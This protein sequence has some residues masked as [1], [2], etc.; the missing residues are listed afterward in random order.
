[1]ETLT[2]TPGS[3]GRVFKIDEQSLV[4]RLVDIRKSS[5]GR[6]EWT[7]TSGIRNVTRIREEKDSLK[8]LE[9][10]YKNN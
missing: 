4:K 6:F 7:D 2:Y 8:L 9:L 1:M 10:A 5:E 3:P